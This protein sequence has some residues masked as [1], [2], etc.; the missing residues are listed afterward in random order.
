MITIALVVLGPCSTDACT[1]SRPSVTTF[2]GS[3]KGSIAIYVLIMGHARK[4]S[5]KPQRG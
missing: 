5:Q 2:H 4:L 3:G 1:R